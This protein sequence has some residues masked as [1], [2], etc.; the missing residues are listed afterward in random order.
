MLCRGRCSAAFSLRLRGLTSCAFSRVPRAWGCRCCA[1][2]FLFL[3]VL[4]LSRFCSLVWALSVSALPWV[5]LL[6]V[7]W[8][9]PCCGRS[10]RSGFSVP[11]SWSAPSWSRPLWSRS[12]CRALLAVASWCSASRFRAVVGLGSWLLGVLRP[13]LLASAV[14]WSLCCFA[15]R[16][17]SS[18]A[19]VVA[20]LRPF[21]FCGRRRRLWSLRR[22]RRAL[23]SPSFVAALGSLPLGSV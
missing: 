13:W 21:G 20:A 5:L 6:V 23:L 22:F 10:R 9:L 12:W 18:R 7:L 15:V 19:A 3:G 2:E 8:L 16:C 14:R 1:R 4:L 11:R 17:S